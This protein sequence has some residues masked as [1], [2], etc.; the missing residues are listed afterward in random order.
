MIGRV[1]QQSYV[2]EFLNN[3][4]VRE[5]DMQ[6]VQNRLSSGNRVSLPSQDPVATINYMDYDSR[7]KEIDVYGSIIMNMDAKLNLTDSVL[8]SATE[9][10]QR[11]RELA[12]Q[13]GNGVYSKQEREI[14][15]LEVD[16]LTRELLSLANS[17]YKDKPLFGGTTIEPEPF[18]AFYRTDPNT[19]VS[20][21]EEVRYVGNHQSQI[22]EVERGET[23]DIIPSGNQIF[24]ADDMVIYPTTPATGYTAPSDSRIVV[25]GQEIQIRR[26]DSIEI[27]ADKINNS[28]AAVRASIFTE[29]NESFFTMQSTRPH[30]ITLMDMDGGRVLEELGLIDAGMYPPFNYS[31][32]ARVYSGSI[33]DVMVDF[34]KALMEDDI[35]RIGGTA[36]ARMDM[37]MSNMMNHRAQ[38]GAVSARINTIMERF[39]SDKVYISDIRQ[40]SIGTDIAQ[41]VMDMKLLEFAHDVALNVGARLMPKS[42]LDFLR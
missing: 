38:M 20:F 30:Q 7:L 8:G 21:L 39:L 25:D 4:Q 41:S 27:I 11:L 28:G 13:M 34:R 24:W 1:S 37:A 17:Y 35:Y 3:A 14:V 12:V 40:K 19:G 31:P 32:S 15:A 2:N 6:K 5:R 36:L 29:G 18:K 9:A 42:L 23:I 26:G 10:M 33:F 16:Q 22:V